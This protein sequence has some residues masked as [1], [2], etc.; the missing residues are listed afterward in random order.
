LQPFSKGE[1]G[2][3]KK[4]EEKRLEG[5]KKSYV[6]KTYSV[7]IRGVGRSEEFAAPGAALFPTPCGSREGGRGSKEKRRALGNSEGVRET[8]VSFKPKTRRFI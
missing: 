3:E 8:T 6:R 4:N 2:G 5:G 7:S 1:G